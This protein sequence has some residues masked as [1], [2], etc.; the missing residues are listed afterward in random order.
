MT[1]TGTDRSPVM[2]AGVWCLVSGVL[3]LS[4]LHLTNPRT[5]CS[6]THLIYISHRGPWH[7]YIYI[8]L[9]RNH[10]HPSISFQSFF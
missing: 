2:S 5:S 7:N 1:G 4:P 8:F 3:S 6:P 9:V 10:N